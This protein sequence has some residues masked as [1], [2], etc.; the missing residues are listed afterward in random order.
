MKFYE[1]GE[2]ADFPIF[3]RNKIEEKLKEYLNYDEI[4]KTSEKFESTMK[5]FEQKVYDKCCKELDFS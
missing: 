1:M 4:N 3:V 5:K 2:S